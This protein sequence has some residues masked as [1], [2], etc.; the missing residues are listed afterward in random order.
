MPETT[1]QA[2]IRSLFQTHN[3]SLICP[4]TSLLASFIEPIQYATKKRRVSHGRITN[5]YLT[6]FLFP[7]CQVDAGNDRARG[8]FLP[9]LSPENVQNPVLDSPSPLYYLHAIFLPL[10]V[11][12]TL[13]CQSVK[14]LRASVSDFPQI[15]PLIPLKTP[16]STFVFLVKEKGPLLRYQGLCHIAP[17][18]RHF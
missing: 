6:K 15:L 8:W 11:P 17:S 7:L 3:A 13:L 2:N 16:S 4:P 18:L 1:E 14:V 9:P 12:Q 10:W 5:K